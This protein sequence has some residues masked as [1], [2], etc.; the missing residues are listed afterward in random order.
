[1]ALQV[2]YPSWFS[3]SIQKGS[4]KAKGSKQIMYTDM[5]IHGKTHDNFERIKFADSVLGD[6]VNYDANGKNIIEYFTEGVVGSIDQELTYLMINIQSLAQFPSFEQCELDNLK[7]M[8]EVKLKSLQKFIDLYSLKPCQAIVTDESFDQAIDSV[9][10]FN[11]TV[12]A[13]IASSSTSLA[14]VSVRNIYHFK[15]FT[16]RLS[17]VIGYVESETENVVDSLNDEIRKYGHS[18]TSMDV[19]NTLIRHGGT[20]TPTKLSKRVFRSKNTITK[21]VDTLEK[22]GLVKREGWGEDRRTT[23]VTITAK[24]LKEVKQTTPSAKHLG[25]IALSCLD[26]ENIEQ[27]NANL[28]Q[29]RQH[30]LSLMEG[31]S[32]RR[33]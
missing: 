10:L 8:I 18:R 30:L 20:M 6:V 25:Y 16:N 24:G 33:Q 2:S 27:L 5:I 12:K 28:K 17:S 22:Q 15:E 21:T 3:R 7:G 4:K 32:P 14:V 11:E 23:K 19:L 26:E 31:S 1:M 9:G 13:I 29:I